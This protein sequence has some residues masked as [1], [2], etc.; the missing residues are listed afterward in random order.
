MAGLRQGDTISPFYDPMIAKL[1]VWADS[2]EQAIARMQQAL[3]QTQ[4]VGVNTNVAFLGRLMQNTAFAS[5]DLDTGLIEKHAEQLLP[6][7]KP[8][9]VFTLASLAA[10]VMAR[11]GQTASN[12]NRYANKADPW[13]A[14]DGWRLSGH[15]TQHIR[16]VDN[17]EARLITLEKTHCRLATAG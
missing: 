4:V 6:A 17:D 16:M 1:I 3:A 11:Q 15:Y 13:S 2:R 9:S 7:A 12:T 8:S 5:A 14:T 10:A